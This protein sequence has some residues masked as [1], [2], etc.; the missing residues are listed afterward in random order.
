MIL[1]PSMTTRTCSKAASSVDLVGDPVDREGAGGGQRPDAGAGGQV[2]WAAAPAWRFAG[3]WANSGPVRFGAGRVGFR[4]GFPCRA[5]CDAAGQALV[6]AFGVVD[7][8]EGVDLGLQLGQRARPAAVCR[9]SGTGSGGS[10]RSCPG[11]SACSGLPVIASTPSRDDVFDE[12]AEVPAPRR[13]E[14]DPVVGQQPLG[15]TVRGDGLVE[16][17]DR[18]LGGLARRDVGGDRVAGVVVDE[19]EDHALASAGE[20]VLGG[21]QLPARIRCRIDEPAPRRAWLLLRLEHGPRRPRGRSGPATP[22]TG[23]GSRPIARIL[24]CTLIGPWSSPE[25]SS[26]AR[27][28]TAWALT[29][30]VSFDGLD[31]GRRVLGSSTAAGP[32]VFARLRNS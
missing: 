8:V 12:L 3:A 24:S 25:A 10:V 7:V 18:G 31:L 1:S 4:G 16:H 17:G 21:V 13:V 19:L 23:T 32:S 27:T 22:S 28:A 30:S 26:A 9:G 15:H 29:S 14:R 11:W 5:G 2:L 20:H 6:G